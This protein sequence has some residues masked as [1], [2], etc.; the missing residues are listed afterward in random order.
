MGQK[1]R[2][3]EFEIRFL[4]STRGVLKNIVLTLYTED[5]RKLSLYNIPLEIAMELEKYSNNENEFISGEVDYDY[6]Y[7]VFEVLMEM[8]SIEKVIGD[9][10]KEVYINGYDPENNAYYAEVE[11][12]MNYTGGVKRV[13]MIPSHAVLL[14]IIGNIPLY[15]DSDLIKDSIDVEDIDEL[16]DLDLDDIFDDDDDQMP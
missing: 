6:R 11:I 12:T 15:V 2:I 13:K 5:G 16:D 10:I 8:P 14:S 9:S 1:L 3:S 4:T 7:T